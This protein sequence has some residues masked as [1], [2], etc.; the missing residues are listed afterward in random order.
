[1]PIIDVRRLEYHIGD[2][3]ILKDINFEINQGEYVALLGPNGGGKST[4]VKLILG[5][6]KPSSG[7]I[8]IFEKPQREF[9]E[10]YKIGYVPQN[11][12][13]F[14]NNFPLSVYETVSLGLSSQKPWFGMLNTQDREAI[15]EAMSSASI[16]DLRDRNLSDLSGGQ[17][18][19][20]MIARA[21]VSQPEVLILDEPSTGVDIT[22]QHKFYQFLK[23]LNIEKSLTIVFVTHDLGVIADDVTHVLAVNQNLLFAGTAKEM[24]SC[25]AVSEVYGT[26]AHLVHHHCGG[27][28][29]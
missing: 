28:Q 21:L 6:I 15:E 9:R 17:R 29:C 24:L 18:Q 3:A 16:S 7:E 27:H 12:S 14:D 11:V 13:L 25:E 26:K 10:W 23:K 8:E 22:T 5:L 4:L 2:Q 19:R 1:M 20:V